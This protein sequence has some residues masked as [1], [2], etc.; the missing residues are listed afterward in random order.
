MGFGRRCC[1]VARELSR[2]GP[3]RLEQNFE[4]KLPSLGSCF[5]F[6][7]TDGQSLVPVHRRWRVRM[8]DGG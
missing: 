8:D 2:V 7:G 1:E 6:F 3:L 5:G 4:S